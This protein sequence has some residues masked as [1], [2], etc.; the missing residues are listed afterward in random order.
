[1]LLRT[2]PLKPKLAGQDFVLGTFLEIP[3]PQLVELLGL[4][5][6]DFV[7]IDREHAAITL[8]Q[9]EELIRAS[10]STG[11]SALVR[12]PACEPVAIRQPLDMGAA[13][14]HVPQIGSAEMAR[15]AV[16]SALFHPRGERG[17]QPF[18]RAASYRAGGAAEFLASANDSIAI[19]LHIEGEQGVRD[20]DRI[21]AVEGV[22]CAFIGPYD[23]SQSLGVPGQVK[24]PR[25]R[26]KIAEAVAGARAA[27]KRVGIYAD[28]AATALEWRALGVTYLAVSMDAALFLS[29]A[30][31]IVQGIK[32]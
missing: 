13:G 14:I 26:E 2:N 4:A 5:G 11:I 29:G 12:V 20:L 19:V 18:V 9:T 10:L 32:S 22:D 31:Q 25:V 28:D 24:H 3:S 15:L 17:L 6:F 27:G 8:A 30:R 16:R 23:L 7:I 1:M 21:L